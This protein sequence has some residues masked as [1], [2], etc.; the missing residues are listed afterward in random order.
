MEIVKLYI[1]NLLGRVARYG[2]S[3][4]CTVHSI[5]AAWGIL[6]LTVRYF[7]VHPVP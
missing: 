7:E 2:T 1:L 4:A 3:S 6:A 5:A